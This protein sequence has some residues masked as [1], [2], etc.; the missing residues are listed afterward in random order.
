MA[1]S[2]LTFS[3]KRFT[4]NLLVAS[5]HYDEHTHTHL[6]HGGLFTFSLAVKNRS[7]S[8][9]CDSTLLPW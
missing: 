3:L 9:F 6:G 2:D 5:G 1:A 8:P 4:V 7:S